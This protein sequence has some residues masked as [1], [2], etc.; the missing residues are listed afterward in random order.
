LAQTEKKCKDGKSLTSKKKIECD[1][2]D[3][4]LINI[5]IEFESKCFENTIEEKQLKIKESSI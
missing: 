1:T 4:K 2:T 5:K 3:Q